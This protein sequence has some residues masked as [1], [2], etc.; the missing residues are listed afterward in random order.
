VPSAVGDFLILDALRGS[1]GSAIAVPDSEMT[2]MQR[3]LGSLG[4]GYASLET[5]AAAAGLAALVESRLIEPS[6]S[7]VLFDT[8]AGFKSQPLN[9][10]PNSIPNDLDYWKA[11]VVPALRH[12]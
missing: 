3:R 8:G 6:D 2:A 4:L 12:R 9:G 1:G 10:A 5:A 11:K 7:V